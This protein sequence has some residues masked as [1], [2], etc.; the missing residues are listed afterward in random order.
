MFGAILRMLA[1][2]SPFENDCRNR[3]FRRLTLTI[4][5][6]RPIF[7][8]VPER[9]RP[10]NRYTSSAGNVS[11]RG[12]TECDLRGSSPCTSTL[13]RRFR[14]A[15]ARAPL[16]HSLPQNLSEA[17]FTYDCDV[18]CINRSVGTT[19]APR[20]RHEPTAECR[21]CHRALC[22]AR[23]DCHCRRLAGLALR[24]KLP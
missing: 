22:A 16:F 7:R 15:G 11:S 14:Q 21:Q 10:F 9:K 12:E 24:S 20:R 19:A 17:V 2:A 3:I 23:N 1:A 18:T 4:T 5:D 13:H 6:M 8:E